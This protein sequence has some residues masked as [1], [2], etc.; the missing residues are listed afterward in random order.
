MTNT[1]KRLEENAKWTINKLM[2]AI[3]LGDAE[4]YYDLLSEDDK[5]IMKVEEIRRGMTEMEQQW[6]R[7]K[8]FTI[9]GVALREAADYAAAHITMDFE[10]KGN[11]NELYHLT[12]E[13]F[14]WKLMLVTPEVE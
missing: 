10:I 8:S 14:G 7:L 13:N 3:Q 1:E 5:K 9:Q 4:G 2:S 12:L 6:G 11:A